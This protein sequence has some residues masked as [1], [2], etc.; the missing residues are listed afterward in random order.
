MFAVRVYDARMMSKGRPFPWVLAYV[1]N[2]V[3]VHTDVCL[4]VAG[5][6]MLRVVS[7]HNMSRFSPCKSHKFCLLTFHREIKLFC[8]VP[9]VVVHVLAKVCRT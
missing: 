8:L 6:K 7:I 5:G 9:C 4:A 1:P 3:S 2:Q